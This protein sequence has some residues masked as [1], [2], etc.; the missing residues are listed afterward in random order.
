MRVFIEYY[1]WIRQFYLNSESV[2]LLVSD[3]DKSCVVIEFPVLE[4][5]IS[6]MDLELIGSWKI[7]AIW[8]PLSCN[9]FSLKSPTLLES[10]LI[11]PSEIFEIVRQQSHNS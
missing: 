6:T 11:V 9:S 2:S 1:F 7:I 5:H 3:V 8:F 4:N 10:K